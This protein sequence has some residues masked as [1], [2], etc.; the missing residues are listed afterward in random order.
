MTSTRPDPAAADRWQTFLDWTRINARAMTIAGVIV[1]AAAASY[2][3]YAR[4]RQIQAANAEKALM[5]AKQSLG[6]GNMP[7]AQ[8]DLQKVYSR[9]S[10]TSAGVEAA[11]LLAQVD[12]DQHKPQDGLNVLKKASG[13]GAA[14][15]MESTVRSLIGDGYMQ[16][17]KPVEAAKEYEAAAAVSRLDNER[18]NQRAKAARAYGAVGDTARARKLWSDLLEDPKAQAM[19][20]EARVRIGELTARVAKK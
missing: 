19:A 6:A 2:W 20:S 13:S 7:L 15:A 16:L 11:L 12:Y 9:Y 5:N 1:A 18:A 4:S 3:F 10:S 8:S 17:G 14:A